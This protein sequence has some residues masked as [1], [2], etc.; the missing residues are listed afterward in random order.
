MNTLIAVLP[1]R[2]LP[3][4]W[5]EV[6]AIREGWDV[7]RHSPRPPLRE[8]PPS[9]HEVLLVPGFLAGDSSMQLLARYLRRAGYATVA[10]GISR[11]VDC[12]EATVRRLESLLER[13]VHGG[14]R[15]SIVGHSRGGLLARALAH[16]RPD[17]VCGVVTLGSPLR[18]QLAVH[19]LLWSQI[20]AVALA[21]TSGTANT[22]SFACSTGPCCA[23][24]RAD[25]E[26]PLSASVGMLSVFSRRDGVVDWRSC[27]DRDADS[28]EVTASHIGMIAQAATF[29]VVLEALDRFAFASATPDG[30][31]IAR[32]TVRPDTTLAA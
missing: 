9:S 3:P 11:N 17:L 5:R 8:L 2:V 30:Q 31:R 20:I 29:R 26:S 4:L 10:S 6:G 19:P 24:Y 25:L 23:R 13:R 32:A 22:L 28:V 1:R 18:D 12:S 16:R 27:R 14:E 15:V 21:G 7:I